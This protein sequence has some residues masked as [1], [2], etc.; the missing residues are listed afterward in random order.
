MSRLLCG[1]CGESGMKWVPELGPDDDL[2]LETHIMKCRDPEC[3]AE[4][5]GI[6][7]WEKAL[8]EKEK[9]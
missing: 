3:A 2:D 5:V 4:F 1:K 9:A 8:D 7:G 6:P